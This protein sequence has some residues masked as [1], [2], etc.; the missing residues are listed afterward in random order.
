MKTTKI[1]TTIAA[2]NLVLFIST[3][4][5]ANSFTGKTGEDGKTNSKGQISAVTGIHDATASPASSKN[6]FNHLRFDVNTYIR[7]SEAT[8]HMMNIMNHLRFNVNHY[9]NASETQVSELPAAHEFDYLRFDVNN[10]TGSK[11][12]EM[13]ELSTK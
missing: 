12:G 8:E 3:A 13:H 1:I 4:S 6:E 10:Y 7:E 5:M 11:G 9:I 2:L